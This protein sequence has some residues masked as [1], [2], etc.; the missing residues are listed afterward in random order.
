M[1]HCSNVAAHSFPFGVAGAEVPEIPLPTKGWHLRKRSR[2][3][4][5]DNFERTLTGFVL[6]TPTS[7]KGTVLCCRP[8]WEVKSKK[9]NFLRRLSVYGNSP[10]EA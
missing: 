6:Q 1:A 8:K 10:K 4:S 7:V 3:K 5:T 9:R 2:R